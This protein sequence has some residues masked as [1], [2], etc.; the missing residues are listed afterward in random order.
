MLSA[1]TVQYNTTR[2][3]DTFDIIEETR[4][5]RKCDFSKTGKCTS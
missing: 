4:K 1:L 2:N 3:T 5:N